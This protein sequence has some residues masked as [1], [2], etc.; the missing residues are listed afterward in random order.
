MTKL[1]GLVLPAIIALLVAAAP[2]GA[3]TLRV[4]ATHGDVTIATRQDPGVYRTTVLVP[5]AYWL[6]V[7]AHVKGSATV[8]VATASGPLIFDGWIHAV[9]PRDYALDECAADLSESHLAVWMLELRQA[10]GTA[11]AEIP[12][13]VDPGP[14][15]TTALTW[16]ASSAA[17][18]NVTAVSFTL[19]PVF[20]VPARS[21]AYMWHAL[22]DDGNTSEV[23]AVVHQ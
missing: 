16:C 6:H 17:D 9:D 14:H 22:F 8:R 15:G 7:H 3:S 21:G 2:A 18:M 23:T 10:N 5:A 1:I 4:T 11:S 13:F 20:G 19:D 12:V